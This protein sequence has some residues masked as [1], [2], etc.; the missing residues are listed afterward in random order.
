MQGQFYKIPVVVLPDPVQYP[1]NVQHW[2]WRKASTMISLPVQD[3][4]LQYVLEHFP[5]LQH[6]LRNGNSNNGNSKMSPEI[7]QAE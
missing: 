6:V 2:L 4:S 1:R 5:S 7:V 3:Y